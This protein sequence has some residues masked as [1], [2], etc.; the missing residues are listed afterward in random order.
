MALRA[1]AWRAGPA[2]AAAAGYARSDARKAGGDEKQQFIVFLD[3][4]G[5][6]NNAETRSRGDAT[7]PGAPL[8]QR[9]APD[10]GLVK[11]FEAL[12]KRAEE[13][14]GRRASVVLSS[15]WR[16]EPKTLEAV[17][18]RLRE[19]KIEVDGATPDYSPRSN[20]Q[21]TD[22]IFSVFSEGATMIPPMDA[23]GDRVDEI[24]SVLAKK[25]AD[26]KGACWVA[27]DDVN[28]AWRNPRMRREHF[29]RTRDDAGLTP[30][31]VDEAVAKLA[32][33]HDGVP[34]ADAQAAAALASPAWADKAL[35]FLDNGRHL[36]AEDDEDFAV[37][38]RRLVRFGGD[39]R[40]Y[41]RLYRET[42]PL[43]RGGYGTVAVATHATTWQQ[44]AVKRMHAEH[45]TAKAFHAASG[46]AGVAWDRASALLD[47]RDGVEAADDEDWDRY[48]PFLD[49]NR[50]G[51]QEVTQEEDEA[52]RPRP[53]RPAEVP[54]E[55]AA[56]V[57]LDH[58]HV[59][60]LFEYFQDSEKDEL[61]LV[62]EFLAG[63]TLLG[64]V[65]K[66]GRLVTADAAKALREMLSAV[67][68]C[69]KH[70]LVHADLKPDN[71][72]YDADP[73]EPGARASLKLIDF[74]L[75][76]EI[77]DMAATNELQAGLLSY[78]APETLGRTGSRGGY[79]PPSDVW[80]L[81]CM[82]FLC[83][84]GEQ[85]IEGLCGGEVVTAFGGVKVTAE[86]DARKA[87]CNPSAIRRRLEA[88]AKVALPA[89]GYDLLTK[90]LAPEP[91]GR[92][93]AADALRHPFISRSF[94]ESPVVLAKNFDRS[95]VQKMR[96]FG[97]LPALV[98][99]AILVE[100]HEAAGRE[101]AL[102]P[103]R[104]TFRAL[105]ANADGEVDASELRDALE[106][107]GVAAPADLEDVVHR[108]DLA[109][110]GCLTQVEFLAATMSPSLFVQE[111][112]RDAAFSA[113]D[114][115]ADAIITAAD[116]E[117]LIEQ[118]PRRAAVAAAVLGE[119]GSDDGCDRKRFDALV[120]AAA[121]GQSL[122]P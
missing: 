70:G 109:R 36:D 52:R 23:A 16:L 5:V 10:R 19:R 42:K 94:R 89:D 20:A 40:A 59:V 121:L 82:F 108:C 96:R 14:T 88:K 119:I 46:D 107:H 11:N 7:L 65:E 68:C 83:C 79:G 117:R 122:G 61:L 49:N 84:A 56:L 4:D 33:L 57:E 26:G 44:R 32:A 18:A 9:H 120:R 78:T 64:R 99:L 8:W 98:R 48:L 50:H 3:V 62:Q 12:L 77:R 31:K 29:V 6:L 73:D 97:S 92:I 43:G 87:I 15:T 91:S 54:A 111:A 1:L 85:L 116:L 66:R 53:R 24:F 71:F 118:S 37:T 47:G 86:E 72:C 35:A 100:A 22:A 45:P 55:V 34:Y 101:A 112:F 30:E 69:H 102:R 115:D 76:K 13:K 63:G 114:A 60:K 110:K 95:M 90:M 103:E 51:I 104:N 38:R 113:L 105:D 21:R 81:G 28:L 75:S 17:E 2:C 39:E 58:P 25:G 67:A 27:V 74:G 80:A 41:A 93:T 106:L